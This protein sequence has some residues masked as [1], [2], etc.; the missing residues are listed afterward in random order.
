[1]PSKVKELPKMMDLKSDNTGC[2]TCGNRPFNH[3]TAEEIWTKSLNGLVRSYHI[4][5]DGK[6]D[7]FL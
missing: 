3:I 7:I 2:L 5:E 6:V 1:M 4:Q